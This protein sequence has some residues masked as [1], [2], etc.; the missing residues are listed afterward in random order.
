MEWFL[1]DEIWRANDHNRKSV[2]ADRF[3]PQAPYAKERAWPD[4]RVRRR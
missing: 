3:S 1:N 2:I 4:G